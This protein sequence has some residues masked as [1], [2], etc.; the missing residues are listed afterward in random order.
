MKGT[1]ITVVTMIM[2]V[3]MMATMVKVT[4][5]KVATVKVTAAKVATVKVT[6]A[7]V[8]KVEMVTINT[9]QPT[10]PVT[11]N[12]APLVYSPH[13]GGLCFGNKPAT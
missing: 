7:K 8:V 13:Q 10:C 9:F 3:M 1:M 5:V 11:G 4:V 6:A 12:L 2:V